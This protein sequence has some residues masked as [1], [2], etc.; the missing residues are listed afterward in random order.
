MLSDRIQRLNPSATLELANKARRLRR[1]GG[2][3][4]ALS[5]GE[6]DF[7]TPG[8]IRDAAADALDRGETGYTDTAGLWELR[9]AIAEKLGRDN[10]IRTAPEN[11]LVTPGAKFGIF[12]AFQTLMNEGETVVLFDPAWVSFE[13]MAEITGAEVRRCPLDSEMLPDEETFKEAVEGASLVVL[14]SPCNPT[15]AVYPERLT[16]SLV[17]TAVDAGA[18][19]LSDEVY[20]KIIYDGR[21]F[22]PASEFDEVV[23][24]NGFSKAY[25]M[26]GWRL[27]YVHADPK[28]VERMSRLQSHSA[29]CANSFAQHGALAALVSGERGEAAISEMVRSF[30]KRRDYLV[31]ALNGVQG[32]RCVEPKGAFYA[33]PSFDLEMGS[34]E[35]SNR[36]LE[37]GVAATPGA[38]FGPGGEGHLRLSYAVSEDR[39]G[40]AVDRISSA[41]EELSE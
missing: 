6:P 18:I 24:I 40:T 23:T 17:E 20:E 13:A 15:G 10:S 27:G 28:I 29:T 19:V 21:H 41:F 35:L 26:T 12:L 38:A 9:E 33:F 34:F 1:D 25:S 8:F 30:R 7:P 2:D 16:R 39:L 14:N 31:D 22:S 32:M 11:V 37:R 36:L 4:V 3:V 5:V